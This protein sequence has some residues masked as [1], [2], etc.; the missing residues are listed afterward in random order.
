M[1]WPVGRVARMLI[2]IGFAVSIG[3][4]VNMDTVSNAPLDSGISR[5]FDAT[6]DHTTA[7][8][9][10]ALA[11]LNVNVTGSKEDADG[12]VYLVSKP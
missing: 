5:S 4:C 1:M 3:G 2:G 8:T 12:T 7:T 11:G 10:K 6:Y 9:L